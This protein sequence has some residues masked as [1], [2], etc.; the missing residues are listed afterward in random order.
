[1]NAWK[2]LIYCLWF[3]IWISLWAVLATAWCLAFAL[4][5]IGE[6]LMRLSVL[7]NKP[8]HTAVLWLKDNA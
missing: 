8:I 3:V 1:M 7:I 5:C 4:F 2:L 6:A